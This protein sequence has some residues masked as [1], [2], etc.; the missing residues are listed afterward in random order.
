MR[1]F[2]EA[3]QQA[4]MANSIKLISIPPQGV[5]ICCPSCGTSLLHVYPDRSETPNRELWLT[6]GDIILGLHNRLKEEDKIT[7]SISAS[8]ELLIGC[9]YVCAS[10]YFVIETLL[11]YASVEFDSD[12]A[13]IY[14][15]RNGDRGQ[16]INRIGLYES[17]LAEQ[18]W[19]V[20]QF[21]TPLGPL[22]HHSIGPFPL[23]DK[24]MVSG[25]FGVMACATASGAAS[26][27]TFASDLLFS[28]M[29]DLVELSYRVHQGELNTDVKNSSDTGYGLP[30]GKAINLP[31]GENTF[32]NLQSDGFSHRSSIVPPA[33][34]SKTN[35]NR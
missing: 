9:C 29:D 25:P 22:L 6:D 10:D 21:D 7:H 12:Y 33:G 27:W 16:E 32:F 30:S 20:S 13:D 14:F 2:S 17:N 23:L 26:P 15:R 4:F 8:H 11:V 5:G 34:L 3:A 31:L 1:P 18:T 24:S 19:W 35:A 28:I